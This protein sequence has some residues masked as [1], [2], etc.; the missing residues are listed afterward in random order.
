MKPASSPLPFAL[1]RRLRTPLATQLAEN[2]RNAILSGYYKEGDILPS[3]KQLAGEL[4]VSLRIPR[5]AMSDL[6]VRGM[7]NPRPRI[8]CEVLPQKT[9]S[10]K[11]RIHV[12]A[13]GDTFVTYF[14]AILFER[15]RQVMTGEGWLVDLITFSRTENGKSD[16]AMLDDAL[17]RKC[18]FALLIYP[19]AATI[20]HIKKSKIRYICFG[21]DS[22]E[23]ANDT[24]ISMESAMEDVIRQ[25][26]R[27]RIRKVTLVEYTPVPEIHGKLHKAGIAFKSLTVPWMTGIGYLERISRRGYELT[28]R[29]LAKRKGKSSELIFFT[30]DFVA[31][32]GLCALLESGLKVPADVNVITFANKGFSPFFPTKLAKVEADPFDLAN[33]IADEVLRRIAGLPPQVVSNIAHYLP[34]TSLR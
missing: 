13:P 23:R 7:V 34:G 4:G 14:A 3:Y 20:R 9:K 25:I 6:V 33:R 21:S 15:F 19:T 31:R 18:D 11:G 1:N 27:R 24:S 10:W 17:T 2:L 12:I 29:L 30:D 26:R 22:S 8:G 16:F 28:R 5:E 32:G